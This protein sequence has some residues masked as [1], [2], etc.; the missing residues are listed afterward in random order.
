MFY[1]LSLFIGLRYTRA[2]R[3]NHFISFI[4][5]ISMLG[6]A[7]GVMVLV[8]VLSVMNGFDKEIKNRILDMVPQV[9]IT[10]SN[11]QISN[12]QTLQQSLMGHDHIVAVEPFVQ[13]EAMITSGFG[14][15]SFSVLQGVDPTEQGK[16]SPIA[17]KVII[18]SLSSLTPK[19]FHIVLGYDLAQSL[20]VSLGDSVTVY[21]P[22]ASFSLVGVMPRLRQFTVSGI[23][24]TGSQFDSSYALINISDAQALLQMG[25]S[26]SG[27]QLK[28]DDL[29]NAQEVSQSLNAVLPP[30]LDSYTWIAQNANFFQALAMEKIMMFFILLLIVIVAAFNMLAS[31]VMMVTDKQAEIAILRTM[32]MNAKMIRNI[33]IIQGVVIGAFGTLVGV[34]LGII[35]SLHVT[36]WTDVIQKLFHIQFLNA[37]VYYIDFLPSS[38]SFADVI[39]VSAIAL[40]LS[41]L[42][43]LYPA[44]R[45]SKINPAEAL[46]YE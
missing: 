2:K 3:K 18:G 10:G 29:F 5:I 8:I 12:W 13:G 28:L 33:F 22:K 7:L 16:I 1:P 39:W 36:E 37:N 26:V 40:V 46:R 34:I 11:G 21:V 41:F 31:L 38:L 43:T 6:I 25:T 9:T 32:G 27:L 45:A 15:P 19:S 23:F 17:S 44:A 24:K 35:V 42:A 30:G 20:G 14:N 4:S